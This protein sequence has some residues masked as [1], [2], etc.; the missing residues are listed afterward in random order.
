MSKT[1]LRGGAAAIAIVIALG[2]A[3]VAQDRAEA[4]AQAAQGV[5]AGLP[6]ALAG[7][8]LTDVQ[9]R[10]GRKGSKVTAMLGD[11]AVQ[12]MFGRDDGVMLHS[13][14]EDAALPAAAV[15]ALVPQAARA[16]PVFAQIAAVG[17]I[18]LR[19][20]AVMVGGVDA[21]G[22][23]VRAGFGP[24]GTL[25]RFGRGDE[26]RGGRGGKGMQGERGG[27]GG[28]GMRGDDAMRGGKAMR[29][30]GDCDGPRGGQAMRGQGAMAGQSGAM[31][32]APPV[33]FDPAAVTQA[34]A[35]AG[36]SA[37]GA[38][39]PQLTLEAVNK[40]GEPVTLHL[41]PAGQ[42]VRETAR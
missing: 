23:P 41:N 40:A 7:L 6:P 16:N 26:M 34:L 29:G 36:Y 4:P 1:I 18:G 12:A 25:L 20:G 2:G 9:I 10:E 17:M 39:S 28:K 42:V 3:V 5:R 35:Q 13:A 38:I 8:G 19:D 33:F 14:D 11:V 15:D 22:Q 37:I 27:H 32:V 21:D 31:R 30:G 24:D